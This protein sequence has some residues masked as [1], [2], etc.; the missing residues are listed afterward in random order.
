MRVCSVSSD[1]QGVCSIPSRH[2]EQCPVTKESLATP[3]SRETSVAVV[4]SVWFVT[5][6]TSAALASSPASPPHDTPPAIRCSVFSH[7]ATTT[8]T[9]AERLHW[10]QNINTRSR[11]H[12]A[13]KWATLRV[14]CRYS[15][16]LRLI[17]PEKYIVAF[18]HVLKI[19]KGCNKGVI[20]VAI[21]RVWSP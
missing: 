15:L 12:T 7:A 4:S 9:L 17:F 16:D 1:R 5:T 2:Q 11:A 20:S 19:N 3:A 6:T 8:F 18:W 21:F 13:P 10:L 14:R